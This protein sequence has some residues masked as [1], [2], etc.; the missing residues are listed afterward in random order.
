MEHIPVFSHFSWLFVSMYRWN[1]HLSQLW[2]HGLVSEMKLIHPCPS[3]W[4][5]LET[6]RL[7][8]WPILLFA[9]SQF[10]RV[11]QDLSGSR[12]VESQ[13][14]DSGWL[15]A[16]PSGS[17]FKVCKYAMQIWV[18]WHCSGLALLATGAG[19]P[20]CLTSRWVCCL[21]L[22]DPLQCGL[23]LISH[24]CRSCSAS[25]QTFFWGNCSTCGCRS[26]MSVG[27]GEFRVLV[28]CRL[29]PPPQVALYVPF[30]SFLSVPKSL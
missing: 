27:G 16:T 22:S 26:G 14:L 23:F 13:H 12:E 25:F 24:M 18:P 20:A 17:N 30:F 10:L 6:L 9:S 15:D 7:S 19:A 11:F 4:L 5:S 2:R 21:S 28:N 3:S 29:E 1:R 8:K